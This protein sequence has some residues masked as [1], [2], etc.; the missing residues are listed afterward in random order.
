MG[1]SEVLALNLR[2]GNDRNHNTLSPNRQ[3]MRKYLN[4]EPPEYQA[5]VI[6]FLYV[7]CKRKKQKEVIA[8]NVLSR[9]GLQGEK[10]STEVREQ[11]LVTTSAV[12]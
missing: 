3:G 8:L 2:G 12:C 5:S 9:T 7:K 6:Q 11:R 10:K 4:P 1:S